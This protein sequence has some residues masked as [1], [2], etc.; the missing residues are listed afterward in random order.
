MH[1]RDAIVD[2][3]LTDGIITYDVA[4]KIRSGVSLFLIDNVFT[5]TEILNNDLNMTEILGGSFA[6]YN[7]QP[8]TNINRSIEPTCQSEKQDD[9]WLLSDIN[10]LQQT[11][12]GKK[13]IYNAIVPDTDGTGG[14]T[15]KFQGSPLKKKEIHISAK[16]ID[17]A[18]KSGYYVTED[19]DVLA[20]EL[21]VEITFREMVKLGL[22]K[23]NDDDERSKRHGRNYRSFIS[24][25]IETK[26]FSQYPISELLG[27]K[28][29]EVNLR[30][31]ETMSSGKLINDNILKQISSKNLVTV[32]AFDGSYGDSDSKNYI[33]SSHAYTLKNF[34]YGKEVTLID[35]Y[36]SDYEIKI[37]WNAFKKNV[38]E[39]VM[40]FKDDDAK[41][42]INRYLP[43]NYN[44]I[45]DNYL[46]Q[47]LIEHEKLWNEYMQM[48]NKNK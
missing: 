30:A 34:K 9:C 44:K 10:A 36:Y 5:K 43:S 3:M 46:A 16:Q 11:E 18:R 42:T 20:F 41:N 39:L 31:I 35:P 14:V 48:K 40:S 12:W 24:F 13:A 8:K 33:H 29:K 4:K 27:V 7:S 22:G 21:A 6:T 1:N 28:A 2:M 26:E 25:G 45:H 17:M 32:C 38:S 15:I 47:E 19:D 37:P 23:R